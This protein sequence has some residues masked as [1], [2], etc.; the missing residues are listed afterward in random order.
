LSLYIGENKE[1]TNSAVVF[2]RDLATICAPDNTFLDFQFVTELDG[3]SYYKILYTPTHNLSISTYPGVN[4]INHLVNIS[5]KRVNIWGMRSDD[6]AVIPADPPKTMKDIVAATYQTNPV[7]V[8]YDVESCNGHGQRVF[9]LDGKYIEAPTDVI[10]FHELVHAKNGPEPDDPQEIRVIEQENL[11]RVSKGLLQ[12]KGHENGGCGAPDVTE[13]WS[14]GWS[15]NC[16]IATAATGGPNSPEVRFLR[17]I[18]EN[19]LLSTRW[20]R[21]FFETFYQ[22]Y[23]RFSPAIADEMHK[24]PELKDVFGWALVTPL[25]NYYRL[26]ITRPDLD[27]N[28]VPMP[29]RNYLKAMWNKMDDWLA[30]IELPTEFESL[31]PEEA[32]IELSTILRYVL[33]SPS[34]RAKYLEDL[35]QRGVLP[36]S[37]DEQNLILANRNLRESKIS[38]EE[39]TLIVGTG[40]IKKE[41]T[42]DIKGMGK[43]VSLSLTEK[44]RN[45]KGLPLCSNYVDSKFTTSGSLLGCF[46]TTAVKGGP[47]SPEVHFLRQIRENQLLRTRW[48]RQFFDT[49]NQHYYRFSPAIADEMHKDSELKEVFGWALVNPLLNYYRLIISR[50]DLDL[51]DV[52][53]PLRN[54]LKAMWNKM[55]DWLAK[56]ELPTEF[57]SLT[58]EEASIELSTILRYV[59][60]SPSARAKYLEDLTQ[61]GVLPLSGDEQNL[62]LAN[63]N[64]R[65]SKILLEDRIKI[66]GPSI[67]TKEGTN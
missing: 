29:L 37:G 12:R 2:F 42:A 52:P 40:I 62:I 11:Y 14:P 38:L 22:H 44:Y 53:M 16:F 5:T 30:K 7:K 27:L 13:G 61:R 8:Y 63:R 55:D 31:T 34:A 24:D 3:W 23:Y 39:C 57:E 59:L 20:G 19:Q 66:L 49:F 21:Q 43:I 46:I 41:G 65:E 60:R 50:P 28:D 10:L 36:L 64:L 32:S 15:L 54:Y 25:L 9:G 17:G 47:N 56:I 58:P 48:G 6:P 35:T 4:L 45:S 26:V 67:I 1:I 33:R 51:N 18:R